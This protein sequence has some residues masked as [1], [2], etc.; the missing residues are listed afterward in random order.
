ML[1]SDQGAETDDDW[2]VRHSIV[3]RAQLSNLYHR[4]RERFFSVLDRITKAIAVIGGSATMVQVTGACGS[5][6]SVTAGAV[7]SVTSLIGLVIG[8][9]DL[10]RKHSD[11]ASQFKEVEARTVALGSGKRDE[12]TRLQAELLEIE[13]TEPPTLRTLIRII[14]NEMAFAA[15]QPD[16]ATHINWFRRMFAHF[17]N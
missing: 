1:E 5:F 9:S 4:R 2:N 6:A 8:F 10:A 15:D 13:R 11:L 12:L 17:W 7:V 14:Q 16:R 3:Y